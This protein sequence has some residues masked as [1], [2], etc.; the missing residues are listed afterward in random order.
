MTYDGGSV[1]LE[2]LKLRSQKRGTCNDLTLER[3]ITE[4]SYFSDYL[5][6]TRPFLLV[7]YR[8]ISKRKSGLVT[9]KPS[10]FS[11]APS[12]PLF[13]NTIKNEIFF[14]IKDSAGIIECIN[15]KTK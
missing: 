4:D 9:C 11:G 1:K 15:N 14:Q 2:V 13:L 12:Y 6:D 3:W 10:Q 5:F 7:P 8:L